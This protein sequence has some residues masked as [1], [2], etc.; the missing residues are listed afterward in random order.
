MTNF[1]DASAESYDERHKTPYMKH[2]RKQELKLIE[3]FTKG[4]ILDLGCGTGFPL[5]ELEKR[6]HPIYG[7]DY[8][9][10]SL[11][12]LKKKNSKAK[13]VLADCSNL[14]FK[15]RSFETVVSTLSLINYIDRPGE[16][17]K[18]LKR[19]SI[20]G[21]VLVFSIAGN[22]DMDLLKRLRLRNKQRQKSMNIAGHK[23]Q[24]TLY[25]SQRVI[26]LFERFGFE[27]RYSRGLFL[28][29]ELRWGSFDPLTLR[30]RFCLYLE[31]IFSRFIEGRVHLMVFENR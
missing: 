28:F 11:K 23:T 19:I 22:W 20:K 17:L 30:D 1:W 2:L 16:M 9:K 3:E 24:S 29:A 13:V 4:A 25:G 14:P 10:D 21:C 6:S 26:E 27:L 15:S 18:E 12:I 7:L 8:S 5:L 31:R